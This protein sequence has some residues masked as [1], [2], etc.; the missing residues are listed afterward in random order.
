M[1]RLY[2]VKAASRRWPVHVF[3]NVVDMALIN[4]WIIYKRVCQRKISRREYI[5]KIAEELTGSVEAITRK[6]PAEGGC[7]PSTTITN[8]VVKQRVTCATIK[9]QKSYHRKVPRL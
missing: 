8:P 5:Q 6:R 1:A 4:S 7:G 3:Y 9:V 2:S